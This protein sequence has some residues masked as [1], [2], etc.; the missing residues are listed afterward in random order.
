M[1]SIWE[2][3]IKNKT[4]LSS[5]VTMEKYWVLSDHKI[6]SVWRVKS[7]TGRFHC[8]N[9]WDHTSASPLTNVCGICSNR[10]PP[11]T[12]G[13]GNNLYC[14]G[15][16][17]VPWTLLTNNSKRSLAQ[18][19]SYFVA[20]EGCVITQYGIISFKLYMHTHIFIYL[21]T[22]IYIYIHTYTCIA[23]CVSKCTYIYI[24]ILSRLIEWYFAIAF[25]SSFVV[26]ISLSPF[27]SILPS[28]PAP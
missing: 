9:L 23:I 24:C 4:K 25:Q 17:E 18:A 7:H 22:H 16:P 21:H 3:K 28:L 1:Q 26:F 5:L 11:S 6:M 15:I 12:H 14:F 27:P 2:Q 8:S 13:N 19:I 10:I 20:A